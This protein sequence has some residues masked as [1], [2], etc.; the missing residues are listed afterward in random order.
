[1]RAA[2]LCCVLA[3]S[4]GCSLYLPT[5]FADRPPATS[6]ADDAP[7]PLPRHREL[8][9]TVRWS[10]IYLRR[11]L[12]RALDPERPPRAGDVNSVDEVP[13]S[14]WFEPLDGEA[15]SDAW[16]G[17]GP[18]EP[19]VEPIGG[20]PDVVSGA[21]RVKDSRGII[22]E[23]EGDPS[24]APDTRTAAG[25]ITAR[26]IRA[27]GYRTAP[28]HRIAIS[29]D[30]IIGGDPKNKLLPA[31]VDRRV[32][33]ATQWPLGTDI[34]VTPPRGLREDDANDYVPHEHRRTLRALLPIASWLDISGISAHCLRD[35]Y[36]G[37]P[38]DG[39]VQ[40]FYVRSSP[41]LGSGRLT[42]GQPFQ[43]AAGVVAGTPLLNLFTLGLSSRGINSKPPSDLRL[44]AASPAV[45]EFIAST[46][47]EPFD[48]LRP[49]DLY[50]ALKR[51]AS[52]SDESLVRAIQAGGQPMAEQQRINATLK[53][54]VL[55][56][57][58]MALTLVTPIEFEGIDQDRL[59]LQD[60][61]AYRFGNQPAPHDVWLYD[62]RG[63]L[64][65]RSLLPPGPRAALAIPRV[66]GLD[67]L[68]VR[69]RARRT[70][71]PRA[72]ELHVRLHPS[73]HLVGILH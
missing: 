12:V 7:I 36:V 61:A 28:A 22:Y 2:L 19:P 18:P 45:E 72:A 54:R 64:L 6:V 39:Y 63:H 26:L 52:I 66:I 49:D 35:V 56:L 9:E 33:M 47:Y 38:G 30:E 13:K 16:W 71:M 69:V 43:S 62:A 44:L 58:A 8:L 37:A 10:D 46:P 73:P 60:F 50:W 48:E 57:V 32:M 11:P 70:P 25:P 1:M 34:G 53:Q 24:A 51:V 65:S 40:H 55:D 67:Y 23:L 17:E 20:K 5:R 15:L 27:I 14:S 59:I 4:S 21:I 3:L 68:V 41:G 29:R 42:Q 31:G